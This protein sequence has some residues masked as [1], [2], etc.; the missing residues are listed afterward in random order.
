MKV[1]SFCFHQAEAIDI[2]EYQCTYC[3]IF[4]CREDLVDIR[5]IRFFC[6]KCGKEMWLG[7]S[8]EEL[9]VANSRTSFASLEYLLECSDCLLAE[10]KKFK[11][12]F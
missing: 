12:G 3:D 4:L 8:A 7:R 1:C 11:N 5:V 6:P 9:W 2:N 10:I